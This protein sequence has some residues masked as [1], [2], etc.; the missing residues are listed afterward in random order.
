[1]QNNSAPLWIAGTIDQCAA[2]ASTGLVKAVVTNPTV[3]ADWCA[4]GESLE[5]VCRQMLDQTSLPLFIQLRGPTT[6]QFL[7]EAEWLK[8]ISARIV[9]KLP[10]THAALVAVSTLADRNIDCLVTTVC[11]LEQAYLSAAARARWIC[12]YVA[13][14]NDAGGD[15]FTL[16]RDAADYYRRNKLRTQ[17]MPASVRSSA[18]VAACLRAGADGVIVFHDLFLTLFEHPVMA[19]SLA[20]FESQDWARIPTTG[21]LLK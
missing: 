13:R 18:D 8:T 6:E 4:G 20:Q 2:D 3:V 9:P 5:S 10:A 1:M 16:I 12:P 21:T 14:V 19:A 15:A 11:S 17:I 7:A